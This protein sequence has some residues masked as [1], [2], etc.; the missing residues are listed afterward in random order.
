MMRFISLFKIMIFSLFLFNILS[1]EDSLIGTDSQITDNVD[2]LLI[3]AK[4][5]QYKDIDSM[6]ILS[7][8]AASFAK[9]Y[10]Y[11]LGYLKGILQQAIALYYN[12]EN[13]KAL[14]RLRA[15]EQRHNH[16]NDK[17]L[18][19]VLAEKNSLKGSLYHS[20][21]L[22]DSAA[23][24]MFDALKTF[25]KH[26]DSSSIARVS[27]NLS[28]NYILSGD[29]DKAMTFVQKASTIF[30]QEDNREGL[31][32]IYERMGSIYAY[33][34]K[35]DSALVFFE[36]SLD[37][38]QVLNHT[39]LIA[40]GLH[41]IGSTLIKQDKYE[42]GSSYLEEA[43]ISF[44][45]MNNKLGFATTLNNL[46]EIAFDKKEY[47]RAFQNAQT[48]SKIAT[49]NNF[50]HLQRSS[51]LKLSKISEH[52]KDFETALKYRNLY[53][54]V[55][56]SVN[57]SEQ[58]RTIK[59]LE[60]KYFDSQKDKVILNQ[61]L[62][63]EQ[64]KTQSLYGLLIFSAIVIGLA[65]LI[66]K[67]RVENKQ[68]VEKNNLIKNQ[69][70]EL[71]HRT[72]NQLEQ[73][74]SLFGIY[75]LMNQENHT[76]LK[77]AKTRIEAINAVYKSLENSATNEIDI[78][79]FLTNIIQNT[80]VIYGINSSDC[81]LKMSITDTKIDA[82][83]AL[84]IG[85]LINEVLN[86]TLKHAFDSISK[87]CKIEVTLE[88]YKKKQL[89]LI[90]NDNG[91][92]FEPDDVPQQDKMGRSLINAFVNTL[93]GKMTVTSDTSGSEYIVIFEK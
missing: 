93:R 63:I 50:L 69:Q 6:L 43:A 24:Y 8:A 27:A 72:E 91:K 60:D 90:I 87:S 49:E 19:L 73:L 26:K 20:Q 78:K 28:T 74:S 68:L 5:Y 2:S 82:N 42:L 71:K 17:E 88:D 22:F 12:G 80:L 54:A 57:E 67:R 44:N 33:Q 9:Q 52:N 29:Y 83:K 11:E 65:F 85:Q 76:V 40:N 21:D 75:A 23:I 48:V 4:S 10:N 34:E 41:N 62:K 38:A 45:N 86:N 32:A 3:T 18:E 46:A 1:C 35:Y 13:T 30:K 89:R 15:I 64:R 56:D 25:E 7:E 84:L 58:I 81:Q 47:Q 77:E 79:P 51:Y 70:K 59:S 36:Q 14:E 16:T 31:S 55:N 61:E 92:G 66:Y 39:Y 53:E 37:I